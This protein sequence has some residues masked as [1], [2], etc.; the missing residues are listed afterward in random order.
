MGPCVVIIM[1]QRVSGTLTPDYR[2]TTPRALN[3]PAKEYEIRT[4]YSVGYST[5]EGGTK[6][7]SFNVLLRFLP[8][9]I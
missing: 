4:L 3:V 8:L 9:G 2:R 7:Q 5:S 1:G 6:F